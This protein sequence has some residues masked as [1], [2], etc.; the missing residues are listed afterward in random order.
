MGVVPPGLLF[1]F[2]NAFRKYY[3][4]PIND[5]KDQVI[6][7]AKLAEVHGFVQGLPLGYYTKVGEREDQALSGGQRQRVAIARALS[8]AVLFKS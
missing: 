8:S 4:V 6:E 2:R 1:I 5:I 3:S 7:A